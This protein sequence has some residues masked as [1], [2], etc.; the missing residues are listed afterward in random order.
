MP[1][2]IGLISMID[3]AMA[4]HH[5]GFFY[6][7]ANEAHE[8]RYCRRPSKEIDNICIVSILKVHRTVC[9]KHMDKYHKYNSH[10]SGKV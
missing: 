2:S 6:E 9:H 7:A 1:Q 5:I 8:D 3:T 4:N 10:T